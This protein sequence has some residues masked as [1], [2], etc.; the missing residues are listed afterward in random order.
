MDHPAATWLR[1][2]AAPY[3]K[4]RGARK[5]IRRFFALVRTDYGV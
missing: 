1:V 2:A 5:E 4:N 3:G